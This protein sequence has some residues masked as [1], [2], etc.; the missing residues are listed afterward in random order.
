MRAII[1]TVKTVGFRARI[2]YNKDKL[3]QTHLYTY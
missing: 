3:E 1:L 2:I